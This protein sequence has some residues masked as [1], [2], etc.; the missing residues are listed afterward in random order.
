VT[1]VDGDSGRAR[2]VRRVPR[3][4]LAGRTLLIEHEA[5]EA[6]LWRMLVKR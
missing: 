2:V 3:A 6:D 4:E 5:I 1:A